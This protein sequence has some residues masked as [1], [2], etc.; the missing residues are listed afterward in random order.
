MKVTKRQDEQQRIIPNT[1][2]RRHSTNAIV[3]QHRWTAVAKATCAVLLFSPAAAVAHALQPKTQG[4]RLLQDTCNANLQEQSVLGGIYNTSNIGGMPQ[5]VDK[6]STDW[7]WVRS[8]DDGSY[9]PA[10]YLTYGF[11][12]Q[13]GP[14]DKFL[15]PLTDDKDWSG[16]QADLYQLVNMTPDDDVFVSPGLQLR[17]GPTTKE[18]ANLVIL[19]VRHGAP[20]APGLPDWFGV[21]PGA[22]SNNNVSAI[23]RTR[24]SNDTIARRAALGT[25]LGLA[26]RG[27]VQVT[28]DQLA[29]LPDNSLSSLE[30]ESVFSNDSTFG[31]LDMLA[32]G[33]KYKVDSSSSSVGR[34]AKLTGTGP[35]TGYIVGDSNSQTGC[36]LTSSY[37]GPK[38]LQLSLTND[39]LVYSQVGATLRAVVPGTW[40]TGADLSNTQGG[41]I[42][43]NDQP[44]SMSASFH[45]DTFVMGAGKTVVEVWDP[46]VGNKQFVMPKANT[47]VAVDGPLDPTY[48]NIL[49]LPLET[50]IGSQ[51]KIKS[52]SS[53]TLVSAPNNVVVWIDSVTHFDK[54]KYV[55]AGYPP[56][57]QLPLPAA[58]VGA[59]ATSTSFGALPVAQAATSPLPPAP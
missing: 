14:W 10:Q 38:P 23:V 31:S 7:L 16:I 55:R 45:A 49:W 9:A 20:V 6:I 5:L 50:Q 33:G 53:G 54:D 59:N 18:Q 19:Q 2:S 30:I 24:P 1:D 44:N 15:E 11:Q 37:T 39:G 21:S 12:N 57:W 40:C 35:A 41:I 48:E 26:G 43:G 22:Y 32:L 52:N 25:A 46:S 58:S 42:I 36:Y 4:R 3:S 47:F 13:P 17:F 8:C 56:L 29:P 27:A 34:L 28:S 51:V